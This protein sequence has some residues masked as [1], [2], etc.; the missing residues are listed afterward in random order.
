M[1]ADVT[2]SQIQPD[3]TSGDLIIAGDARNYKAIGALV[4]RLEENANAGVNASA[5]SSSNASGA[6]GAPSK[7]QP[8]GVCRDLHLP[9]ISSFQVNE[10][11]PQ[12]TVRFEIHASWI[13]PGPQPSTTDALQGQV[14][15]PLA[16]GAAVAAGVTP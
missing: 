2:L 8:Q 13:R 11:D 3:P 12:R 9:Y 1:G 7:R 6:M 15:A 16:F 10:Q 14:Q 5:N 4:A